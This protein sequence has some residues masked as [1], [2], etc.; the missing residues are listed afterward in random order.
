MAAP[1]PR[2]LTPTD[3]RWLRSLYDP[4]RWAAETARIRLPKS[5]GVMD[6]ASR[7]FLRDV[8]RDMAPEIVVMK[9]AQLGMSTTALVRA[10]WLLT[11]FASTAIYTMPTARDVGKFTQG[12]INPIVRSSQYLLDRIIDVDSVM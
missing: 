11:S 9:G 1:D 7:P 2:E 12:R 10:M 5:A 8:Y 3:V 4:W 6:L